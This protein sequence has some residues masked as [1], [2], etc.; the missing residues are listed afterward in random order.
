MRDLS[1]AFQFLSTQ[2]RNPNEMR[3]FLNF[4][5]SLTCEIPQCYDSCL[6]SEMRPDLSGELTQDKC[7]RGWEVDT[8]AH[9]GDS[10]AGDYVHSLT[11]T[12]LFSG[13]T[14]NRAVWNKASHAILAQLKE[15]EAQ[16]LPDHDLLPQRQWQ[17]IP[18]LALV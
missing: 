14:E 11:F 18:Q 13:W 5:E 17:R 9:C 15:L 12:D 7:Y 8:V 1:G 4:S 2:F 16:L 6:K 10:V 3:F